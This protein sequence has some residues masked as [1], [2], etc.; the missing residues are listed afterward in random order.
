MVRKPL[1]Q[2]FNKIIVGQVADPNPVHEQQRRFPFVRLGFVRV[3]ATPRESRDRDVSERAVGAQGSK[4][5]RLKAESVPTGH[6]HKH[7]KKKRKKK[8]K[9]GGSAP[10]CKPQSPEEEL[11]DGF[12][13]KVDRCV[14][15]ERSVGQKKMQQ[16]KRSCGVD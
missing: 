3:V 16:A 2:G 6:Q 11:R 15:P 8:N 4:I 7:I 9:N 14:E 1:H 12:D 5:Q 13:T 10:S